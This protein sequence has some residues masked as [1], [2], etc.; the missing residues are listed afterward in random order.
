MQDAARDVEV[1]RA[2][3]EVGG[4]DRV[5]LGDDSLPFPQRSMLQDDMALTYHP[6]VQEYAMRCPPQGLPAK[7]DCPLFTYVRRGAVG[8]WCAGGG[9][10]GVGRRKAAALPAGLSGAWGLCSSPGTGYAQGTVG[11]ALRDH[12]HLLPQL[13]FM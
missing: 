13:L 3:R 7:P 10:W 5:V 1:P 8:W 11:R 9:G 4:Q 2:P 6:V 12:T